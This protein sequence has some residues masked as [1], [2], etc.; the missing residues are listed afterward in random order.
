MNSP[1]TIMIM[2]LLD[3]LHQINT[4]IH[5]SLL[6]HIHECDG[7]PYDIFSPLYFLSYQKLFCSFY[8]LFYFILFHFLQSS[9]P[10]T[11]NTPCFIIC[12]LH[13]EFTVAPASVVQTE[14]LTTRFK[15]IYIRNKIGGARPG[16]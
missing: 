6:F 11:L 4:P 1:I 14:V 7:T 12:V 16:E 10:S 3:N 8:F 15:S 13:L 9:A 5:C 2:Q